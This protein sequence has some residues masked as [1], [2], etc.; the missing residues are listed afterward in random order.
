MATSSNEKFHVIII[1]GGLGGFALAQGLRKHNISCTVY[2]KNKSRNDRLQG[3]RIV[4]PRY[5]RANI[6]LCGNL[7]LRV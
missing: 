2:E 1:G 6:S 3:Y 7:V 5:W 4:V